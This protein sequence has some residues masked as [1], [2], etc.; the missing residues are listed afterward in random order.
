MSDRSQRVDAGIR[1]VRSGAWVPRMNSIMERW[2]QTCRCELLERT[3]IRNQKHLLQALRE[4]E[5]F[6]NEHRPHRALQQAAPLR[7]LPDRSTR[8]SA[9]T[10]PGEPQKDEPPE[11]V[12]SR[13]SDVQRHHR[14]GMAGFE[15]TTSSSRTGSKA[16]FGSGS[17]CFGPALCVLRCPSTPVIIFGDCHS[18]G[19]SERVLHAPSRGLML[20]SER[21]QHG[22][23]CCSRSFARSVPGRRA[24]RRHRAHVLQV[25]A[26]ASRDGLPR[27]RSGTR[28]RRCSRSRQ[29]SS[30]RGSCPRAR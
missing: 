12:G 16:S 11:P 1:V 24:E 18:L 19:T 8:P 3:L 4:F 17:R 7:A 5:T 30:R 26:K 23:P 6:S 25:F 15:P 29:R 27:H 2:I 21:L 13:G 10:N 20:P 22:V 9:T 28:V 14:V